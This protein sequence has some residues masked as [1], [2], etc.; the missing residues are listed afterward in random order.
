M[1]LSLLGSCLSGG[2]SP[3]LASP[4]AGLCPQPGVQSE[5]QACPDGLPIPGGRQ[6]GTERIQGAFGGG[7]VFF[8]RHLMVRVWTQT[9]DSPGFERNHENSAFGVCGQLPGLRF[10]RL[11]PILVPEGG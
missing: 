6:V 2:Q 8:C 5:D 11:F 4:P 3:L 7:I 1:A 9:R 10:P